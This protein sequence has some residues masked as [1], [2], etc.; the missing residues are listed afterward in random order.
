MRAYDVVAGCGAQQ[1]A[2]GDDRRQTGEIHEEEGGDALD[3][4][5]VLEVAQVPRHLALHVRYQASEQ[6]AV[7]TAGI[8]TATQYI[9]RNNP[10][11]GC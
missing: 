6:S 4:E 11:Q 8:Q 7:H 9:H 2:E 3:V 5:G 1:T 10:I